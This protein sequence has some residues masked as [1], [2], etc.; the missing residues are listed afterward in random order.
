MS[1]CL[2][3]FLVV[4]LLMCST[5]QLMT[6]NKIDI[7]KKE[8]EDNKSKVLDKAVNWV[9]ENYKNQKKLKWDIDF[10]FSMITFMTKQDLF[11]RKSQTKI[12]IISEFF[13]NHIAPIKY[14]KFLKEIN[15]FIDKSEAITTKETAL[16]LIKV[17]QYLYPIRIINLDDTELLGKIKKLILILFERNLDNWNTEF[18]S[19]DVLGVD[20]FNLKMNMFIEN[21]ISSELKKELD[22]LM[23]KLFFLTGEMHAL[24]RVGYH[25]PGFDVK[26]F[27]KLWIPQY[28]K[29]YDDLINLNSKEDFYKDSENLEVFKRF[30]Y[31]VTHFLYNVNDYGLFAIKRELYLPEYNFLKNSLDIISKSNDFD[32]LSEILACLFSMGIDDENT[33]RLIKQNE[34][35]VMNEQNPDGSWKKPANI[36]WKWNLHIIENS[37]DVLLISENKM[38][39]V[40]NTF[41]E[42]IHRKEFFDFLREKGLHTRNYEFLDESFLNSSYLFT[43]FEKKVKEKLSQL[44]LE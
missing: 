38:T 39:K 44:N 14:K 8:K 25:F 43:E 35:R 13:V 17:L 6:I 4:I 20:Q 2:N 21:K 33:M 28:R 18:F 24:E 9:W 29:F 22:K 12:K 27:M 41:S 19:F 11:P 15:N 40:S 1:K 30:C 31:S 32:L 26:M 37:V 10:F 36:H 23:H 5:S 7:S 3:T 16:Y 42:M 34:K